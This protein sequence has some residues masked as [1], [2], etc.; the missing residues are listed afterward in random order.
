MKKR[1]WIQKIPWFL[2]VL[3]LLL[4]LIY[5]LTEFH[6]V[7]SLKGYQAPA[8]DTASL[9]WENFMDHSF[10][11]YEESRLKYD[12][13]FKPFYVRL[14][15]EL[16]YQLYD[17]FTLPEITE[18][19]NRYL[20]SPAS[21]QA[22]YGGENIDSS[23]VDQ[24]IKTLRK[25]I[26]RLQESGTSFL[27]V[28]EPSKPGV[29]PEYLPDS[30]QQVDKPFPSYHLWKYY[31]EKYEIP[32]L[33]TYSL[34]QSWKDTTDIALFC[35][36]GYHWSQ[37]SIYKVWDTLYSRIEETS[38]K[39]LPAYSYGAPIVSQKPN[40]IDR[41][42]ADA[43]NLFWSSLVND[44]YVYPQIEV[45]PTEGPKPKI[46]LIGDSFFWNFH[47]DDIPKKFF[48]EDFYF[49]YYF[50][51]V[52]VSGKNHYTKRKEPLKLEDAIEGTDVVILMMFLNN[53]RYG[54]W[55]FLEELEKVTSK[56]DKL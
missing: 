36:G 30:D 47:V 48:D 17:K 41:D 37:E 42:L 21:I 31:L 22:Y 25:S 20:Y 8:K 24:E 7:R 15:N 13:R 29:Y 38:T 12:L 51:Q 34:F 33:D 50:N 14:N 16:K 55:G 45:Q 2:A 32:I 56:E 3:V 5:Q 43:A 11:N 9:A 35:S 54:C 18:G 49:W 26:D 1:A 52:Y 46:L 6:W 53:I 4:P 10:Q 44:T 23:K 19:K 39:S 27:F 28:I 40:K